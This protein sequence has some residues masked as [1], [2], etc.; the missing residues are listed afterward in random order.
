MNCVSVSVGHL[1]PSLIFEGRLGAYTQSVLPL[2]KGPVFPKNIRLEWKW[3]SVTN[4]LA[5]NPAAFITIVKS[6]KVQAP[7]FLYLY[8]LP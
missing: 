1:N 2:V 7:V 8:V 6:F 3:L 4:A 5:Y